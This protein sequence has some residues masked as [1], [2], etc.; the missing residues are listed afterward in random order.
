M[1]LRRSSQTLSKQGNLEPCRLTKNVCRLRREPTG[2]RYDTKLPPD[3]SYSA[4]ERNNNT[5]T[6][7]G[8]ASCAIS[9]AL[10]SQTLPHGA[11]HRSFW[12]PSLLLRATSECKEAQR[13]ARALALLSGLRPLQEDSSAPPRNLHRDPSLQARA[14]KCARRAG[15]GGGACPQPTIV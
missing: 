9:S 1:A 6:H 13:K 10:C 4:C 8:A 15:T 2:R 5:R 12:A 11:V 7:K 3:G 14:G